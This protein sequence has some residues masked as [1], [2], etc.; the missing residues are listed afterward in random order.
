MA[1]LLYLCKRARPDIKNAVA[2]LCTRVK[3]P[4]SDDYKKLVRV[5]KYLR[6]TVTLPLTLEADGTH[7]VQWWVDASYATH[8]DMRSH[9]GGVLMLGKVQYMQPLLGRS[10]S[11]KAPQKQ[12]S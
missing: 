10:C 9:T 7:T 1:K 8:A 2:F 6:G 4:D 12:N 3:S 11:R 5:M